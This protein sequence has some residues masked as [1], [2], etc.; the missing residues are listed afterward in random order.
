MRLTIKATIL[1]IKQKLRKCFLYYWRKGFISLCLM[2]ISD[3]ITSFSISFFFIDTNITD[4]F[5]KK[6]KEICYLYLFPYNYTFFAPQTTFTPDYSRNKPESFFLPLFL[7][8][9]FP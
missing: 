4:S 7:A 5:L 6:E 2:A 3:F 1:Q 8:R 9:L